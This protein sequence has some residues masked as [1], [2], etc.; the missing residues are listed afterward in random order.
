MLKMAMIPLNRMLC[1][2]SGI[3]HLKISIIVIFVSMLLLKILKM[4]KT[5]AIDFPSHLSFSKKI[6][7]AYKPTRVENLYVKPCLNPP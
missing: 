7:A 1:R 2:L 6:Q 5:F 4:L 3:L